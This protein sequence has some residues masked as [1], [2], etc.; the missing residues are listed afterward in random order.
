M[1]TFLFFRFPIRCIT[2]VPNSLHHAASHSQ[3]KVR[4][5]TCPIPPCASR[6][7]PLHGVCNPMPSL[8]TPSRWL[9]SLLVADVPSSCDSLVT[10]LL[11]R[12]VATESPRLSRRWWRWN[13][14]NNRYAGAPSRWYHACSWL[15][16]W[17]LVS[18]LTRYCASTGSGAQGP[19]RGGSTAGGLG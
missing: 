10:V 17:V 11:D 7:W 6:C 14:R 16:V 4:S 8:W 3:G 19:G 9:W 18:H 5:C 13:W 2:P 15:T 12:A 1:P